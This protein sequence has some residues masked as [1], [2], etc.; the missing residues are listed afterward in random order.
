MF[1]KIESYQK[2]DSTSFFIKLDIGQLIKMDL[3][4]LGEFDSELAIIGVALE[5]RVVITVI[6]K[7]NLEVG[8]LVSSYD[9]TSLKCSLL[10]DLWSNVSLN[11][12]VGLECGVMALSSTMVGRS[13]NLCPQSCSG[14]FTGSY[15]LQHYRRHPFGNG[16]LI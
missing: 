7:G 6:L 14:T 11:P 9:F 12:L 15:K 13:T 3:V 16:S 5:K 1:I 8:A 4:F 10:L 2:Q